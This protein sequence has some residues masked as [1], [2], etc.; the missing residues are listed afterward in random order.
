[1][2]SICIPAYNRA[3]H[4]KELLDS[5]FSQDFRGFTVV[6]CEDNSPERDQISAI[7]GQYRTRFPEK[8]EYYANQEN[9]GFDANLRE[10]V[11]KSKG[12][13]CFFMG[14]DDILC[15]GALSVVADIIER[16]NNVGVILKS[17]AW[18]DE[19]PDRINQTIR[20][21]EDERS[22]RP[23]REAIGVCFR[24]SGVISGYIVDR[25]EAERAATEKFDGT[26]FYQ[27]HLTA[28]ALCNKAAVAT[29]HVLVLCRNGEP[30]DFGNSDRETGKYIPGGFT[31]QARVNMIAGALAIIKNLRDRTGI[32][33]EEEVMHDYANYFYLCIR[34]QL[35]LSPREFFALYR[36]FARLGFSKF[37]SFHV[38]CIVS[39]LFGQKRC[40]GAIRFARRLL[41]H[42]PHWGATK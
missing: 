14:N 11:A 4:L 35:T 39:Y 22:F 8:I 23:G 12:R 32:D 29:P 28:S 6:I 7:V 31:P 16:Y 42:S 15:P 10:L 36:A 24:R 34:D 38:Y 25:Q 27:M 20:Y 33:L 37:P 18:F 2:F 1:M 41:G 30:P 26:L 5:I 21:F 40:D 3:H 13:F 9:L 19:T 17:Y